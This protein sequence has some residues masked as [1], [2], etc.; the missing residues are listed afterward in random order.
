MIVFGFTHRFQEDSPRNLL[1]AKSMK[2][3]YLVDD[4]N[5]QNINSW[6]FDVFST[7]SMTRSPIRL[8]GSKIFAA[9]GLASRLQVSE[10]QLSDFLQAVDDGYR[11]SN[12]VMYHNN[13]H[14]ADVMQTCH[15]FIVEI[16]AKV[17]FS[18]LMRAA[19]IIAAGAHD[20]G[21][22]GVNNSYLETMGHELAIRYNNMSILENFHSAWL[23]QLMQQEHLNILQ[24]LQPTEH[25]AIRKMIVTIILETDMAKHAGSLESFEDKVRH[26]ALDLGT[27]ESQSLLIKTMMHASDI[28]NPAKSWDVYTKWTPLLIEEFYRQGDLERKIGLKVN[29]MMDRERPIPL[30]KFQTGF[31]TAIVLPLFNALSKVEALNMRIPCEHLNANNQ[32]WIDYSNSH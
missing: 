22:P 30:E 11:P 32:R 28:A 25:Q 15:V 19:A 3:V 26:G 20:V 27:E 21:H 8:I 16:A 6:E 18:W 24:N 12:N 29:P 13:L 14:G 10:D 7:K 17:R 9:H 5:L 23:F 2:N 31:I 1:R 4:L